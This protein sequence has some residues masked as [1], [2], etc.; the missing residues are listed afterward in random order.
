MP[1]GSELPTFATPSPAASVT[2]PPPP[3]HAFARGPTPTGSSSSSSSVSGV[4]PLAALPPA[5]EPEAFN[6]MLDNSKSKQFNQRV[7]YMISEFFARQVQ[8]LASAPETLDRNYRVFQQ[9]IKERLGAQWAHVTSQPEVDEA[10]VQM[11]LMYDFFE[12]LEKMVDRQ[13]HALEKINDIDIEMSLFYKQQAFQEPFQSIR[14]P[15]LQLSESYRVVSDERAPVLQSYEQYQEFIRIFREKAVGD[16]LETIKKQ[17]VSRLELDSFGSRLG[18]LEEKKLKAFAK[19]P[20]SFSTDSA[21]ERELDSTRTKFHEAKSRY[22]SLSTS[23]IDKA[24]LLQL[25]RDV[26]FSAHLRKIVEVHEWYCRGFRAP[27]Q[28][29]PDEV[30]NPSPSNLK[31]FGSDTNFVPTKQ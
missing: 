8:R 25:K 12:K 3:R 7:D 9:R 27:G 1:R 14:Q 16:A 31:G 21:S 23:L 18:Q 5:Q 24:G 6:P 28:S 11:Q 17:A 22:Q 19:S 20:G 13:R 30:L 26:D 2:L 10:V 29:I 4:D 15:M